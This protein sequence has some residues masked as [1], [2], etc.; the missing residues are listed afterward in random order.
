[1]EVKMFGKDRTVQEGLYVLSAA[2][3]VSSI[4]LSLSIAYTG[5]IISA[6]T[7][8]Q[9]AGTEPTQGN[10]QEV[11]QQPPSQEQPLKQP[12]AVQV[13]EDDDASL[14]NANAP[15]K[16]VEFSDYQ[17]P[18]CA[19]F[20]SDTLPDLKKNFIDTGKA[21]FVYRD[22]P[23]SFHKEAQKAAE[24]TECAEEQGKFWEMHDKIFENQGAIGVDSLKTY[25][26]E[27][28]LDTNQ[29]NSCLDSGKYASEVQKDFSDG[30]AAGVSGTPTFFVNGKKL[31]GAQP[32]EAF[33]QIINQ[34]LGG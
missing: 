33:E 14:G 15:V 7:N 4:I 22:F 10:I 19:R 9:D 13:S 32:Y 28:G 16:I 34:E 2:I 1:M 26:S 12:E 8:L 18:F 11:Q 3:L 5:N 23:L 25:A 27:L 21:K 6:N 30:K 31:V 17:C 24:A 29:F 20:Y